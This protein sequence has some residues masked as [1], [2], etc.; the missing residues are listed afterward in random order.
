LWSTPAAVYA[1]PPVYYG[2]VWLNRALYPND[3]VLERV[4]TQ[5]RVRFRGGY[6]SDLA[7]PATPTVSGLTTAPV[8]PDV[9]VSW[10]LR[11][12]TDGTPL[13][14]PATVYY[15]ITASAAPPSEASGQRSVLLRGLTAGEEYTAYL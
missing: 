15:G 8:G 10:E 7:D 1:A 4:G 3:A 9:R 12:P 13:P 6:T 11:H 5:A 14:L 2:G